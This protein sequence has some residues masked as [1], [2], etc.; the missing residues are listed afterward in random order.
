MK[1]ILCLFS[2]FFALVCLVS[3]SEPNEDEEKTALETPVVTVNGSNVS[4]NAI[5]DAVGYV[6]SINSVAQP[7]QTETTYK[8]VATKT[9]E[10]SVK[11]K[12]VADSNSLFKDSAFS[13]R[14][15][16]TLTVLDKDNLSETTVWVVGDSTVCDY[17]KYDTNGVKTG[18]TDSTYFY[19]RYGYATQFANYLSNKV[20][21]KNLALSGRSSKS[22]LEE[23]NYNTLMNNISSGDYLVIGFGH[24]D[25]KSDNSTRFASALESTDTVGSFKYNLYEYYCKLA[26]ENGATPIICSPIVR[27]S[28]T[29]DYSGSNGHV[30]DNGD[31]A[32]ACRELGEEKGIT[33]VDL[34][35]LTKELYTSLGYNE[36]IYLHA[37]SSGNSQ[38]EPNLN[39][40]DTTHINIYG[41]KM[42]AYLF[43]NEL[44][45]T[46]CTLKYYIN[47]DIKEPTKLE[48]LVVNEYFTYKAYTSLNFDE[49]REM[50]A[51]GKYDSDS[52]S[53]NTEAYAHFNVTSE[54]WIGTA[55]GDLGGD[56]L[57]SG[58]GYVGREI[59][60]GVFEV[61][62]GNSSGTTQYKGKIA[63]SVEGRGYVL[64]K[65]DA[66]KNFILEC[67]AE[68]STFNSGVTNQ[69]GFGLV[70]RDEC[71]TATKD[72]SLGLGNSFNAGF[73]TTSNGTGIIF[74]RES[75]TTTSTIGNVTGYYSVGSEAHLKIERVGQ[76]VY[77]TV[78]YLDIIYTQTYIDVDLTAIDKEYMYV[79][80]YGARGTIA[81][82]TNVEFTITG[83][84][85][86][87]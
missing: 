4:W 55:F 86:G 56:P 37:M 1:K 13:E 19:D 84:S 81:T 71:Y 32:D 10:Y 34:T 38:T 79:G 64:R 16:T 9:G 46:D 80:M 57:S 29:D 30:T 78:K 54:G 35:T 68:V 2:F 83:D 26:K 24:N 3:C 7:E 58:N 6:V 87:A 49:Y 50:I 45:N 77:C 66:S 65:V 67:D 76:M 17:G 47:N 75:T 23:N 61:G 39:S 28:K 74:S 22:F 72:S 59:S 14:Q 27:A 60:S 18:V 48:D 5:A 25:E 21:V 8:I 15:V 63:S 73:L 31:Y 44:K 52:D 53:Y 70:L 12:A 11:V 43:M 20:T 36:A 40:V 41:A 42:V 85:Q 69:S 33:V 51:T 62:Q 82:Y